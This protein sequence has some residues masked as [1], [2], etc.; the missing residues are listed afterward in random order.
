MTVSLMTSSPIPSHDIDTYNAANELLRSLVELFDAGN[1]IGTF[2]HSIYDTA[3]VS[4]VSRA[5]PNG[6]RY[7]VFPECFQFI[8]D[9][10]L[11]DG[12]WRSPGC[13]NIHDAIIN[14]LACLLSFKHHQRLGHTSCPLDL[15]D[16]VE[17]AVSFLTGALKEWNSASVERIAFEMIIPRLL[18]L[19][20]DEGINFDFPGRGPLY[21]V[22]MSKLK[23][24]NLEGMYQPDALPTGILHSLE[25]FVGKCDFDRLRHHKRDGN[26]FGSPASTAA[27]LMSVSE[28]DGEAEDYLRRV[29]QRFKSCGY[30]GAVS[31]VW[32]TTVMEFA[33]P[34]CN[35][36]E[37][38]FALENLDQHS[39]AR[40]GDILCS[41]LTAGNGVIGVDS[42]AL[43]ALLHID[44]GKPFPLD[45]LLNAFEL[46]THFQCFK[47]ER[48]P[49]VSANC[50][51]LI[52]F[53]SHP[54]PEKYAKQ[55]LKV[56]YFLL[57]EYWSSK[58]LVLDKWH[59]SPWYPALL[60]TT[61]MTSFLHLSGQGRLQDTT[62]S[63]G[64]RLGVRLPLVLFKIL[65]CILQ[66]K[67]EDGSWGVNGN[68]EETAYCVL[69]L[70]R[71]A[72]LPCIGTK[73]FS[74]QIDLAIASGRRYLKPWVSRKLE[75]SSLIWIG[76]VLYSSE[77]VCRSY[78]I[79][80][81]HAPVPTYSPETLP[82]VDKSTHYDR[83]FSIDEDLATRFGGH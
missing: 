60:T 14:T 34:V 35:L 24:V 1:G 38:G 40:I 48:N 32:P 10:Q 67:N 23:M 74:K 47:Y 45:S 3:W 39:L 58:K 43:T 29:I 75:A 50:H 77:R 11:E 5:E 59:A 49:S 57:N 16:R 4:M 54:E 51:A 22:Y 64:N 61:A 72:S 15:A 2:S 52:A 12:S 33:W 62:A 81:L 73:S 13:T 82:C 78:V 21:E 28:W 30:S 68:P 69:S 76:K 44:I 8:Y 6:S 70:A 83:L 20:D 25:A 9:A 56:M 63:D 36:L 65:S 17:K 31:T 66:T 18:E 19:L 27:Y 79:A 41:Y 42:K 7:R 37:S 53:L 46:P 26:F 55:I 71:L 80:A